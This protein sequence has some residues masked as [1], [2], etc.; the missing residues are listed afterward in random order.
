MPDIKTDSTSSPATGAVDGRVPA[1]GVKAGT[2]PGAE[3]KPDAQA[4]AQADT[5]A[6]ELAR[7]LE[8]VVAK[9]LAYFQN[10]ESTP[11]GIRVRT[12]N[13]L[14]SFESL[15]VHVRRDGNGF[16]VHD[17]GASSHS[18]FLHGQDDDVWKAIALVECKKYDLDYDDGV[19]SCRVDSK[20]WISTAVK[21]V[22]NAAAFTARDAV[23]APTSRQVKRTGI[24][25]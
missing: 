9:Q 18:V 22:A 12:T 11:Q 3:T 5:E 8:G 6:R 7:E 24:G 16:V 23:K 13:I 21:A 14:P 10:I 25:K 20:E 2:T 19:I 1:S 15:F 17:D 4:D